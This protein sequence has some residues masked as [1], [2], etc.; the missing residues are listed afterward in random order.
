MF[1]SRN[2]SVA[3]AAFT[4]TPT[5]G[6]SA[7]EM[8]ELKAIKARSELLDRCCG[9]GLWQA[10][11]HNADAFHPQ[12]SWTWSPEFRRLIGYSSES[13]FPNVCQSWSDKLHPDDAAPTFAAFGAHLKDRTGNARYDVTYR[14]M[15]RSGGYRWFRATGGCLH[16]PDG[17]TILTCGSL[18]D[19]H[20][21]KIVELNAEE[22]AAHDKIAITALAEGLQALRDGN[23]AFRITAPFQPKSESLKTSFNASLEGLGKSMLA[24]KAAA[25]D[26]T[27]GVQEISYGNA[28]LSQ[29]T[30]LQASSL[31]QTASSME[32]MTSTVRQSADNSG[33]ANQ[34]AVAARGQADK[35]G[36]VVANA[37]KA[38]SEITLASKKIAD[39][40]GV[41]EEIAFQTN[42]LAL[43]AAVEA[44]R[45]GDQG[46]G[47]AV[48]ASE[49]RSLAGRSATAA[50]EIKGLI[51]DSLQK[52]E[53]GS[54]LVFESGQTLEQ[55]VNSVKKVG[56][57]IAELAAGGEEQAS[58]IDTVN[59]AVA[60][61]DEVTQQNAALVEEATAASQ[62]L[63]EQ[64]QTMI[65]LLDK[66][67]LGEEGRATR[68]T[69]AASPV[70]AAGG[71]TE[72]RAGTR[73]WSKTAL[74]PAAKT[75][76]APARKAITA[77]ARKAMAAPVRKAMMGAPVRKAASAPKAA[78]SAPAA[79]GSESDW[80]EF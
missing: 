1:A 55:I 56:D 49:V 15:T 64:S 40:S 35:G 20:Q 9:V 78:A 16:A 58:G 19:I 17:V 65:S 57:I 7:A 75:V 28:D 39:I 41:V 2:K 8:A 6:P 18:S 77:P 60:K 10:V 5:A 71:Q 33:Q 31:E 53:E 24:I 50:K 80:Q 36:V 13:D 44:A 46:R 42:L 37:V 22:V 43:N 76:P 62:S 54:A 68:S 73:P 32:R 72:R 67:E 69:P 38:M 29:R 30:E 14:L 45:A 3:P 23:L 47:F 48:V 34:L 79:G 52:V 25:L 27:H 59:K 4:E 70:S 74:K 51:R 66:Y 26:V 21:Q 63:A 61:L 12:S 11:L